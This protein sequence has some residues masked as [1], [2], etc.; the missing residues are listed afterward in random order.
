M[1]FASRAIARVRLQAINLVW[2]KSKHTF[3]VRSGKVKLSYGKEES[4]TRCQW[5][6]LNLL[7]AMTSYRSEHTL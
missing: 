3:L 5:K 2:V 4:S 6:T 1:S 7:Y